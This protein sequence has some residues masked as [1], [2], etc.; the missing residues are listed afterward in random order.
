MRNLLFIVAALCLSAVAH[1]RVGPNESIRIP[2]TTA[3]GAV[4]T[5]V[6]G[7]SSGVQTNVIYVEGL[8]WVRFYADFDQVAG[9]SLTVNC[10]V[11]PTASDVQ[12]AVQS[13]DVASTG[14]STYTAYVPTKDVSGGS[15]A[16][17]VTILLSGV[18]RYLQ[19]TW[20]V[21]SATSDDLS[22]LL[23]GG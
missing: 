16:F 15:T 21:T 19:C 14:V 1:A 12:Y 3:A 17:P 18:D 9:A 13:E 22:L 6:T 7:L 11:G 8:D 20:T 2:I 23:Y 4:F 10:N 5:S